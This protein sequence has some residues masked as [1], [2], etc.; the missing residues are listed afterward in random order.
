[1]KSYSDLLRTDLDNLRKILKSLIRY[2]GNS[3]YKE[4]ER[5]SKLEVDRDYK[6]LLKYS[7]QDKENSETYGKY[8]KELD[9]E[10]K[11][12]LSTSKPK[13]R[14]SSIDQALIHLNSLEI[15]DTRPLTESEKTRILPEKLIESWGPKFNTD[16]ED[17]N[18]VWNKSGNCTAFILRR[19]VEKAIFHSFAKNKLIDKLKDPNNPKKFVGLNSMIDK[20]KTERRVNGLPFLTTQTAE[21]LLAIKYLGDTAAHDFLTDIYPKQIQKNEIDTIVIALGE[22][23]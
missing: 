15:L 1:M 21:K 17:L 19:I 3:T 12:I 11:L 14:I 9:D 4:N 6:R 2:P 8:I 16:N 5:N 22:L 20:A 13:D 18:F 23:L 7:E 10:I